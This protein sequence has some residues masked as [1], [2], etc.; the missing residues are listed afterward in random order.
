M[1]K[2]ILDDI[3]TC[4]KL[5]N[6]FTPNTSIW[7]LWKTVFSLYDPDLHRPHFIFIEDGDQR[8]LLP[9]WYDSTEKYYAFFGG[10][11]PENRSFWFPLEMFR[12]FF[13]AMPTNTV[14]FDING[15]TVEK[16]IEVYPDF[17][18]SFIEK[19][20]RYFLNLKRFNYSLENFFKTFS[21]K[22]YKN[23]RYDLKKAEQVPYEKTWLDKK[24]PTEEL[25]EDVVALN[26]KRFGINSN[27]TDPELASAL[28]SF[29]RYLE[30]EGYLHVFSVKLE[31]KVVGVGA[32]AFYNQHYY[33]FEIDSDAECKNLGKLITMEHIRRAASLKAEEV[34]LLVGDTGWKQLWNFETESVYRLNKFS[35]V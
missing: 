18:E 31:G 6:Q 12:L 32:A 16:I 23:L 21:H 11:F 22:H 33:L 29:C 2:I 15:P 13:E 10:S 27:Y 20:F 25:V 35:N 17:A 26:K 28:K 24:F 9:L 1:K 3:D 19:D 14:L 5:W 7:D 34:D 8:G 4:E 30:S